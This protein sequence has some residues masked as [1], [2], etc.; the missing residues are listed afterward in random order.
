MSE[1][2]SDIEESRFEE[3]VLRQRRP[4]VVDFW[5]P[6]CGPC[7]AMGPVF[8]AL[9]ATYARD[10]RFAKCNVDQ[11]Q[12]VALKYGIKAIPTVMI[13]QNGE[14]IHRVTGMASQQ[15][16]ADAIEKTLAG[17]PAATPFVVN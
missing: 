1:F 8:T 3:Q 12:S 15:T 2:V 11:N 10:V 4:V 13:F 14:M 5:A 7:K 16:L 9:A 17:E 6:W